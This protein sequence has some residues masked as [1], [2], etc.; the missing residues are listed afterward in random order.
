MKLPAIQFY[1]AD[2]RKDIGVQSLSFHDRAIWFEMLCLMHE[3]EERGRLINNGKPITEEAIARLIGCPIKDFKKAIV[4]ILNS[5]VASKEGD[6]IYNRRMVKDDALIRKRRACGKLGG[7]PNLVNQEVNHTS[8]Q[9]ANHT[10]NQRSKQ[11]PTPSSSISSSS[12]TSENTDQQQQNAHE[13]FAKKLFSDIGTL[14][15][16]NIELQL[17]P[18]RLLIPEDCEAFNRHLQTEGKHHVHW[19]EYIKHLRNWLNTRPANIQ[20]NG[21]SFQNST[22]LNTK[23]T[24]EDLLTINQLAKDGISEDN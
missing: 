1:P 5:G 12:S 2:W 15:R 11:K 23:M 7:N 16:Q 18:R 24:A 19:S 10:P 8:N 14:D 6:V 17:N 20:K 9:T 3:S 21:N 22:K 4:N 13:V